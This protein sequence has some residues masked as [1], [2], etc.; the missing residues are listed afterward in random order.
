MRIKRMLLVSL[1]AVF[2]LTGTGFSSETDLK[3][4]LSGGSET[5]PG[6]ENPDNIIG[7]LGLEGVSNTF[8]GN[9]AGYAIESGGG[10]GKWNTF[11][12][13]FAGKDTNRPD[14]KG[15]NTFVGDM[16]GIR[17]KTGI[18][19]TFIGSETGYENLIG[20]NNTFMGYQAGKM[21]TD[22][23]NTFIGHA[24]GKDNTSGF[25][26][27]Y[28]GSGAGVA[29]KES[30]QNTYIGYGAGYWNTGA[31]NTFIG[32]SSGSGDPSASPGSYNTF[33]GEDSGERNADGWHNTFIG[34]AA[35]SSNTKGDYNT[36]IGDG[37]G[38]LNEEGTQNTFIGN[39]AGKKNKQSGSVF[40]GY[41]AGEEETAAN[42][43][44]IANSDTATPLIYGEFD[45]KFLRINGNF[46]A[47]AT[48]VSSDK[49]LKKEIEPIE[50]PLEMVSEIQGVRYRWKKDE[51]PGRGFTQDPQIG[52]IAQDVERV[53]PE[54]VSEDK[55]GFKSVS[56]SKLTAVLVEAIKELKAQN[57][58][59]QTLIQEQMKQFQQQ[60]AEMEELRAMI[61]KL[62]S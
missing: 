60:Q 4:D 24:A 22:N 21:N 42:R 40:L 25:G 62:E 3:E 49:R 36:F 37:A 33:L 41:G 20:Y 19:N 28:M 59:Q 1:L 58:E 9:M 50:S 35:G 54:L 31:S 27:V 2:L 23:D 52:L 34:Y 29:N 51:F 47:T 11:I 32:G 17:N 8:Y 15:N 30:S 12:G 53:L 48:S 26:N 44:H 57:Q 18:D 56:Y 7:P 61:H 55:D 43:L 13:R 10:A 14:E 6:G 39:Y 38:W 16:A 5:I 45:K 46:T